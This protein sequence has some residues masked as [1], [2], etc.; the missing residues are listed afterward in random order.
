[1][2]IVSYCRTKGMARYGCARTGCRECLEGLLN[3]HRNLVQVMVMRQ[4]SGNLEYADLMQAGRIGL[5]HAI[6]SFDENRG[7]RFS[8][9]ACVIILREVWMAVKKSMKAE[10]WQECKRAGDSLEALIEKWYEEQIRQVLR[11]ELEVLPQR[12]REVIEL[13]YGL[14]GQAP[15]NLSEIGRGWGLSREWIRQL[16]NEAL[17]LLRLPALSIQ[18]R[19]L[20]ERQDRVNYRQALCQNQNWQHK[21]RG[22]R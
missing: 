2:E 18:L 10:G 12:L 20:C 7:V 1:M 22:R 17:M 4:V 5:W 13:H 11:E 15:Q 16:H 14:N 8:T 6:L 9:Y 19:S 21:V 3:E